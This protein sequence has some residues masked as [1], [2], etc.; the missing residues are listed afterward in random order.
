MLVHIVDRQRQEKVLLLL[1]LLACS[2]C[3]SEVSEKIKIYCFIDV[4]S[5]EFDASRQRRVGEAV[6]LI[7]HRVYRV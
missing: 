6:P 3:L 7:R 2:D 4:I 1:Q 5:R